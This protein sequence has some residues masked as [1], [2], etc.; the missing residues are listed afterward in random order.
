LGSWNIATGQNAVAI[1]YFSESHGFASHAI[2]SYSKAAATGSMTLADYSTSS[3]Y[4]V[5]NVENSLMA[6][7]AKGYSFITETNPTNTSGVAI[8]QQGLYVKPG[9]NV[10]IGESNRYVNTSAPT[11]TG[12]NTFASGTS[13][14]VS[15]QASA[16]IGAAN[17]VTGSL[18]LGLGYKNVIG[19]AGVNNG[20]SSMGVGTGNTITGSKSVGI[21]WNNNISGDNSYAMG[22]ASTASGDYSLALGVRA[23]AAHWGSTVLSNYPTAPYNLSSAPRTRTGRT[24]NMTGT[25]NFI[26]GANY[27]CNNTGT[28]T[29]GGD[30]SFTARFRGGYHLY[31]NDPSGAVPTTGVFLGPGA[32]AWGSVSDKTKKENFQSIDGEELLAKIAGLEIVKWKYIG[33][34]HQHLGPMA[35][36]FYKA[37]KLG[38]G[39][40]KIITTQDIEG[41]TIAG[42]QALEKRTKE[43]QKENEELKQ[44]LERLE[45]LILQNK[46]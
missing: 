28:C 36:D 5:N 44:R 9:G 29:V 11:V 6:R 13:N 25:N 19:T 15:G 2:G 37:F 4:M 18:A 12:S 30:N 22:A 42:V 8:P 21:G 35:Q 41:V 26:V 24:V 31:T 32:N 7:F 46:K 45:A 17:T 14:T 3:N 16:V 34:K 43:L 10:S 27:G 33:S 23:E 40:D 39:N 20:W 1:G 38:D